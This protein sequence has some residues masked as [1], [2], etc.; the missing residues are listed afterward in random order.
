MPGI[1]WKATDHDEIVK[2]WGEILKPRNLFTWG[3]PSAKEIETMQPD[4]ERIRKIAFDVLKREEIE[5]EY[6]QRRLDFP[7]TVIF[8]GNHPVEFSEEDFGKI[9][10]MVIP[11]PNEKE[12]VLVSN[13][14]FN[15]FTPKTILDIEGDYSGTW[16]CV[17]DPRAFS[18]SITSWAIK[19]IDYESLGFRPSTIKGF[20]GTY[21]TWVAPHHDDFERE[22]LPEMLF[23]ADQVRQ[24]Q[25]ELS[26]P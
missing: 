19:G 25:I 11:A 23:Y 10:K 26:S 7:V 20:L 14:F 6:S 16:E 4:I 12:F 5:R 1:T 15:Y 17:R 8:P 3:G 2:Q 22:T 9:R 21:D 24:Y 18:Y 13:A